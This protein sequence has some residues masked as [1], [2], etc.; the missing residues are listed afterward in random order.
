MIRL[1]LNQCRSSAALREVRRVGLDIAC[2]DTGKLGKF[3]AATSRLEN[4]GNPDGTVMLERFGD[5]GAQWFR[6]RISNPTCRNAMTGSMLV[7][8]GQALVDVA[9]V[10]QKQPVQALVI[11]G[12]HDAFCAGSHL[13]LLQAATA[14][15]R[16][17]MCDFMQFV[18]TLN[19]M[20]RYPTITLADGPA[21]GGGAEL[22]L[23]SPMNES[24]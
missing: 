13:E 1:W 17:V 21:I 16:A 19:T 3:A 7:A 11:E 4:L 14:D 2:D 24:L 23:V 8:F 22:F 6:I 12:S 15:D 20:Q 10:N 9:I 5:K 18:T